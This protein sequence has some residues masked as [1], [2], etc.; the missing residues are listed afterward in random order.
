MIILDTNVIS[1]AMRPAPD[2][3]VLA[4]VAIAADA[5]VATR[6]VDDFRDTRLPIVDPWNAAR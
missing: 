4:T 2:E 5:T 3:R 6:N 1:E